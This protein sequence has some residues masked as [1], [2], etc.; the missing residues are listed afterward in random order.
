MKL[1]IQQLQH[2]NDTRIRSK[3]GGETST[4]IHQLILF[5]SLPLKKNTHWNNKFT[6]DNVYLPASL[7]DI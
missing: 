6:D 2:L 1:Q 5:L 4:N 3:F 7:C